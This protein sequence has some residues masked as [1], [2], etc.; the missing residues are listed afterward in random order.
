MRTRLL[1]ERKAITVRFIIH[2]VDE[3]GNP[4]DYKGYITT[5]EYAD[6]RLGEVFAKLDKQGS[7]VSG[8]LD[9]WAI[10]FSMLLQEGVPLENLVKKYKGSRFP[11]SGR[12]DTPDPA[13]GFMVASSPV[14][15]I[16]RWLE[17]KYGGVK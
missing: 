11:P 15:Y 14:D 3:D 8:F 13:G 4:R 1:D 17:M 5:G 9:A 10:A 16:V 2:S 6:G 7:I 12:T